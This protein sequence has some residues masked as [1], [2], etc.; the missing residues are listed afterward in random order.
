MAELFGRIAKVII[1]VTETEATVFDESF[2]ISFDVRKDTTSLPNQATIS[3]F[4]ISDESREKIKNVIHRNN[5]LSKKNERLLSILLYAGYSENIGYEFL[6]SGNITAVV[7]KYQGTDTETQI[8]TGDGVIPLR[9]TL[10]NLSFA[11]GVSTKTIVEQITAEMKMD[12]SEASN[13]INSN[14]EF[15]NGF[16]F[17]GKAQDAM[18]RVITSSGLTWHIEK[19]KIV[20]LPNDSSTTDEIIVLNKATGLIGSPEKVIESGVNFINPGDYDGWNASSL[21]RPEI[22]PGNKVKIESR[23]A[24]VTMTAR[25]I[26]HKGDTWAGDWLTKIEVRKLIV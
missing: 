2:K 19:N 15:A 16:S 11:A 21:L 7:D 12:V 5:E 4:N 14:F 8:S 23:L 10:L 25:T 24:N 26:E 1:Q 18:D 13:F 17:T 6:Y 22:N 9:D 20:I 3:I